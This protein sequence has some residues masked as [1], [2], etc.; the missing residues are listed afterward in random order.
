MKGLIFEALTPQADAASNRTDIACF[1]GFAKVR[2]IEV[3]EDL[4]RWLQREGWWP[5]AASGGP[6]GSDSLYDVPVTIA[7]WERFDQL[8]AWDERPY[9]GGRT[10]GATYLGAAVRSFFAQGGRKC[11]VI[12]CGE[13]V[14]LEADRDQRDDLLLKLVP[15]DTGQRSCRSQWHGLHHLFGLPGASFVALPD[16]AELAAVYREETEAPVEVP[17]PP[18]EFVECSQPPAAVRKEKRVVQLAAPACTD[19]EYDGWRSTIQRAALFIADHRRDMQLLAGLPMPRRESDAAAGLLGFM[20]QRGWL[21]GALSAQVCPAL[22]A[23]LTDAE[24]EACSIASAFVQ[25]GYPWLQAGYAGD[26]PANLEP[27]EGVMAGL[28]AR[29]AL[30]RGTF[31]SATALPI[32]DLVAVAPPL[33]ASQQFGINPQAPLRASPQ[34]PLIDRVSLFGPSPQG[35]YML[36]DVT[37]SNDSQHRQ[38]NISRTIGLVM[39]VARSIGEEYAFESAGERI[40]GQ[41]QARLEDV[42]AAMQRVGALAGTRPGEAFQVRC[43][44]STMTQQDIDNGR[45][46]AQVMIRPVASIETMRIQ[47]AFGGGGHVSLSPLGLEAA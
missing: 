26:L 1:I 11:Y 15:H 42:L 29:N 19:A 47:L 3:P 5:T 23:G 17:P 13:P 38:A 43:D 18:P 45:V 36:S 32:H 8:F 31:C 39:R 24:K 22:S 20:H 21:S 44:R 12:S 14:A 4:R 33:R 46:I 9:G 10:V 28:L 30:T 2:D 37:T 34:A 7:S 41:L 27:P 40:W 35:F 25:L 16:L 6:P